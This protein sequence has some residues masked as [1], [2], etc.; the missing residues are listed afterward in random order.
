[1]SSL[2]I[3]RIVGFTG[4]RHLADP[5]GAARAI[6]DSLTQL[7]QEAPGDW[8]GLSSVA[9]G[10]DQLFAQKILQLGLPWHAI[11]PLPQAVFKED[12]APADWANAEQL[13]GQAGHLRVIDENGTRE[14]GYLDCGMETVNDADILIALWDGQP[15]RGKGGTA[16]VV[17][18]ASSMGKPVLILDAASFA[19]RKLNWQVLL[20][21]DASLTELNR[22]RN[23]TAHRLRVHQIGAGTQTRKRLPDDS[24]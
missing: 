12:F 20:Q 3:F 24:A 19:V 18:Y 9:A 6:T 15:A 22:L 10:C 21:V 8:I 1:M 4:H 5:V 7:Q 16:D 13:L 2:P 11:L 17:E 23:G 14:D